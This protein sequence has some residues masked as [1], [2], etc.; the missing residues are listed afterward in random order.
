MKKSTILT[1]GLVGTFGVGITLGLGTLDKKAEEK[2]KNTASVSVDKKEDDSLDEI[3][4]VHK[5]EKSEK[6]DKIN[7]ID[8]DDKKNNVKNDKKENKDQDKDQNKN[9]KD[10]Q[11][12]ETSK[13]VIELTD[14]EKAYNDNMNEH[15]EW[16]KNNTRY[17]LKMHFL[18]KSDDGR[19]EYYVTYDGEN[20]FSDGEL[21]GLSDEELGEV[22]R[23]RYP[24][25]HSKWN[26][27][28]Y[29]LQQAF[30]RWNKE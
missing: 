27:L 1:L 4:K 10:D 21:Y 24:N 26:S 23:K 3:T 6:N 28:P 7:S 30:I 5:K 15:I 18:E 13:E 20:V 12:K 16:L 25:G 8:N 19:F 14:D 17:G 9:Q 11:D 29:E 22:Y 2:S